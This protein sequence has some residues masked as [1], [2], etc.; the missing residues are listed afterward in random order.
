MKRIF[1]AALLL[2]LGCF[3]VSGSAFDGPCSSDLTVNAF[4]RPLDYNSTNHDDQYQIHNN[5]ERNHFNSDVEALIRGKT[6]PLP[7]DISFT[8]RA[9]PN[10]YR[11]LDAMARW[12]LKNPQPTHRDSYYG[13]D[14]FFERAI[15]FRP[16]DPLLH[17]LY[18][19]YLHKSGKF[20]E[21]L[22]SYKK[23]ELLDPNSAELQYNMGLVHLELGA[24]ELAVE[25]ATKAYTQA[26]PL[27]GLR[28]RLEKIGLW[29]PAE[30]KAEK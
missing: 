7:L 14:C 13:A 30:T 19:I 15:L 16:M 22:A 26:Y 21:A 25:Y 17:L 1:F 6:G 8:L 29:K 4:G 9:S 2:P 10:H 23:S 27:P 5:V 3:P 20:N 24:N 11:A 12:Q 18:G 28:N